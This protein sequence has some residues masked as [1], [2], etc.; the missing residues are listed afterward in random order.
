MKILRFFKT[1]PG[2]VLTGPKKVL[3]S[4]VQIIFTK[5]LLPCLLMTFFCYQGAFAQQNDGVKVSGTVTDANGVPIPSV[6][7]MEKN[8]KN[9][10]QTNF[11]G[12]YKLT[13]KDENA[14]L[15]FTYVGLKKAE[16]PVGGKTTLDVQMDNDSQSLDEVVVVGYGEQRK[17][18]LVGA[19]STVD[20]EVLNQPVADLSTSLAGRI[21]GLT[22]VQRSG[23]PGSNQADIWIR[24]IST[25][26]S[27]GTHPLVLVD[28]VERD[29]NNINPKDIESFTVLKDAAATA[30]YGFR[31]ANGVIL[32]ETKEGKIGKPKV[33]VEYAEGFTSF[34]Q[35]PD[36]ADGVKY[37]ELANQA[38][39]TRG[40]AP[41]YTQEKIDR[42]KE[43]Q[44]PLLYP[45]VDWLDEV[46][47]DYGR[48]RQANVNVRG[49][50]KQAKY[51]VSLSYYDET[52]LFK[53]NDQEDYNSE[54]GF[55]R[56]NVTTNLN[57]DITK[58][59]KVKLGIQ[60]YL[61]E[62]TL[63]AISVGSIYSS[64]MEV[65]PVEYPVLY[66]GGFVPGRSANGGLRNPY[67]DVTK[68]GYKDENKNQLYSNLR[69]TQDLSEVVE[70]LSWT[71]LFSFD[72]YNRHEIRRSKRET[73]Y[74]V[75]Q[76]YPYTQDGELLLYETYS[77]KNYLGYGRSNGGNRRTY[78]ETSFNYD[79]TFGKH[80]VG[81]LLLANRTDYVNAFA[82]DFTSSL[83][84]RNQGLAG[85]ITYS[86]D[87]R[88]FA[89]FNAG[90]N[91]SEN[92]APENRYGFFP[93][94]G[95]GWV[96]SN[97]N[98]F[99]P[100]SETINFLKIRYSDG[101]VGSDS[102]ASRFAYLSRV[103]DGKDNYWF[104]ENPKSTGGIA[105]TYQGV[106]VTWAEARKQDL[107]LELRAFDSKLKLTVDFFKE[108]TKGAFLPRRDIPNYIGL[109]S[110]PYGNVGTTENK[111]FDGTL[112]FNTKLNELSLSFRGTFS[113]NKNKVLR[114]AEPEQPYPWL[115][116]EGDPI[117]AKYGLIAER[118][119]T[120]GDD[121]DGDG[122]ITEDD[123]FPTQ[124]GQIQP[125]DIKY[126]DLNEDGKI[127]S[128][129]YKRIGDGD[130]PYWTIG[131]GINGQYEGFDLSLF[132]QGQF[133]A[134]RMISGNGVMPFSNSGG[135]G[136]LFTDS[137][138]PWTPENDDPYATVPRLS[139]G[140][141]G[142][143][144]SNNTKSSTWWMRDIDFLRLKTAEIGFT[145]PKKLSEKIKMKATRFYVRGANLL[146]FSNFELWDPE[147]NTGN[148][149][150][151]PNVTTVSLGVNVHF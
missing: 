26:A 39:T 144:Q 44:D 59:T 33:K 118:L 90:Y 123:G 149:T 97:E 103:E 45:N 34:T 8:T 21:A 46:F 93:S 73:T 92:F 32:I 41:K 141:S 137:T 24:G 14:V 71:G 64:A 53:T 108:R 55:T 80:R 66:P 4:V 122:F 7:V 138:N 17:I 65:S 9:G 124:F 10:T 2:L 6:N 75:D 135:R 121:V 35:T 58:T 119:F 69:I 110:D 114:N 29:L 125:G 62:G 19:Q 113:Y 88:Y 40:Q 68:R 142:V 16:V 12:D 13:V 1:H 94:I 106:D 31:G 70:G 116:H 56:Y 42:T 87:D 101:K 18:S 72:A 98:F 27:A 140:A 128:Y 51:F 81:G 78:M 130:L 77:G 20:P 48:N 131:Y 89:E 107:G 67:A 111:G 129:D 57:L 146:T 150:R 104:G 30:V 49:G 151:Y 43:G 100:L 147:L 145:L 5:M 85:R 120:S 143:G 82:G 112:E 105:E 23:L 84:F 139:Y 38:L 134:S 136:N 52:G 15:I 54:T 133:G 83:P 126:K 61:S 60:G 11:D 63:P 117:L 102:G 3:F 36:L 99:E 96:I 91:G 86:Y 22:G 50:A 132:F 95:L 76:N 28:G 37:M 115:N 127:D 25:F 47:R 74:F 148:G 109:V 79:R